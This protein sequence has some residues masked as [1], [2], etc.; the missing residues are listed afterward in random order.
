M[1]RQDTAELDDPIEMRNK[2]KTQNFF[3]ITF[4]IQSAGKFERKKN[5]SFVQHVN[6]S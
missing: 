5:G 1:P 2:N 6:R 4:K 3:M